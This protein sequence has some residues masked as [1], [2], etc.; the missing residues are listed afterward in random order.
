MECDFYVGNRQELI[1]WCCEIHVQQRYQE[2]IAAELEQMADISLIKH[3]RQMLEASRLLMTEGIDG[4]NAQANVHIIDALF[5]D[6][7]AYATYYAWDLPLQADGSGELALDVQERGLLRAD[8]SSNAAM[9]FVIDEQRLAL[10]RTRE[11]DHQARHPHQPID[12]AS[13]GG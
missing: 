4:P 6:L 12:R 11:A 10:C 13:D 7:V 2:A 3:L 9:L 5:T 1:T 8:N